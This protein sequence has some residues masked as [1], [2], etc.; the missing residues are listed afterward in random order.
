[1]KKTG[2]YLR[3]LF[4]V[5]LASLAFGCVCLKDISNGNQISVDTTTGTYTFTSCTTGFT[6]TGQ[7]AVTTKG[8]V[9]WKIPNLIA[10]S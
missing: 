1:M 7:G 4:V 2:Y 6:L 3:A 10:E 5:L 8:S 9:T